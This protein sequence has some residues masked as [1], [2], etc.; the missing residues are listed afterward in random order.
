MVE[1]LPLVPDLL[2][3][4][5]LRWDFVF[6]RPQHLMT[7]FA[8]QRRVFFFEEPLRDALSPY[9]EVRKAAGDVRVATPHLPPDFSDDAVRGMLDSF[10]ESEGLARYVIWYYTPMA[11]PFSR[12][13]APLATAYDCMDELSLFRGAPPL[14]VE[15]EKELLSRADV[16]FTGGHS[17]YEVKRGCHANVHAFPSSVDVAHF[18]RARLPQPEPTDQVRIPHPRLGFFG[19]LDERFDIDLLRAAAQLRPDWHFVLLGPVAKIDP[20]A[21]PKGANIHYLGMKKYA[22]L[23]A[24]LAGWDVALLLFERNEA[25]RYISPTKTPEYLA[26]GKPVVSTS[27]RDVMRPYGAHGLVQIADTPGDF[28]CAVSAGLCGDPERQ[29]K[30]DR[31]LS[32]MS[33]D[34]TWV[35]MKRLLD[36]CVQRQRARIASARTAGAT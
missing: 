1:A 17:L 16:V 36:Q 29:L 20:A 8:K 10:L 30:A 15:L 3:F 5:H 21:L 6:Q 13:L 7:R 22:E 23:P 24:Y 26:A 27:I 19:V 25:T 9:L 14:L 18:A 33:W 34:R 28:V 12:H 31:Y 11:L 4:S 2:C 32:G 35:E